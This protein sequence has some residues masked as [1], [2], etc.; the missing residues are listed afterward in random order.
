MRVHDA[1]KNMDEGL[2]YIVI[3]NPNKR[4]KGTKHFLISNCG[5]EVAHDWNGAYGLR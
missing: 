2:E 1:R 4:I 3:L 5:L